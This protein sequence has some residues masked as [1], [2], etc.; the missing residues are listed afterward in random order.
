MLVSRAVSKSEA[1]WFFVIRPDPYLVVPLLLLCYSH[2]VVTLLNCSR[3]LLHLYLTVNRIRCRVTRF[4]NRSSSQALRSCRVEALIACYPRQPTPMY[5]TAWGTHQ[6]RRRRRKAPCGSEAMCGVPTRVSLP[7]T[8]SSR[9][10]LFL[11]SFRA[12]AVFNRVIWWVSGRV[13]PNC[14]PNPN[15]NLTPSPN[16]TAKLT[17]T[18]TP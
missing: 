9:R 10:N 13:Y 3:C 12:A 2:V 8:R 15:P 7:V 14:F 1:Q 18:L 5:D 11:V 16:P 4:L 17:I 6:Q